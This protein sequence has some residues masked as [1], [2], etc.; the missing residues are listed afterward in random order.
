MSFDI[1]NQKPKL[2]EPKI[3]KYY[4]QKLK[5]KQILDKLK[6]DE[7]IR[8]QQTIFN[9]NLS[10]HKKILV[11]SWD[12]IKENY[13]FFLIC[14]LIII[15]LYVRYIEVTQRKTKMKTVIDQIN[16]EKEIEQFIELQKIN[17]K[18]NSLS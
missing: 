1:Y 11:N 3:L 6:N 2:I 12:F 10:I 14:S 4:Y 17:N 9:S 18:L 16:K 5:R 7:I 8:N 13:G 15:L